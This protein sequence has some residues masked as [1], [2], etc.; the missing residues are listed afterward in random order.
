[1]ASD[2]LE[3]LVLLLDWWLSPSNSVRSLVYEPVQDGGLVDRLAV[4]ML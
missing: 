3:K 4:V 1:M 2:R